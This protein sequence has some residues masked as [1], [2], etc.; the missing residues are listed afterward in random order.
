MDN[1]HSH[2]LS[3]GSSATSCRIFVS[4]P[5]TTRKLRKPVRPPKL[6][7]GGSFLTSQKNRDTD[8]HEADRDH[9]RSRNQT[10][11]PRVLGPFLPNQEEERDQEKIRDAQCEMRLGKSEKWNCRWQARHKDQAKT[12]E[13][14]VKIVFRHPRSWACDP[15]PS[16]VIKNGSAESFTLL[17]IQQ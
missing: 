5:L 10:I 17:G 15:R 11:S 3:A 6:R 12:G 4:V 1:E 14:A 16:H 2:S 7:L 8:E 9:R 13:R